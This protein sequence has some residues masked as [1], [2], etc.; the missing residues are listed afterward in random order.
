MDSAD[1]SPTKNVTQTSDFGSTSEC[2][3]LLFHVQEHRTTLSDIKAA[4]AEN[5]LTFLGF[6][7]DPFVRRQYAARFP[8]DTAMTDLDYWA[9]F[10]REHPL[11]F[12]RMYQFW[13]QKA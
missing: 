13:A 9:V 3:D 2:R 12:A 5:A 7:I 8:D 10:E 6:E 1:G 11:T 4:L